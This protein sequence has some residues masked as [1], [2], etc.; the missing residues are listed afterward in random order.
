VLGNELNVQT[1][2]TDANLCA[3]HFD[4]NKILTSTLTQELYMIPLN[5]VVSCTWNVR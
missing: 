2:G 3:N 1:V 5:M 4:E